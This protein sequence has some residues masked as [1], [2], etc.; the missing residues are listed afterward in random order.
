[1]S[2]RDTPIY[3]MRHADYERREV[4]I[5]RRMVQIKRRGPIRKGVRPI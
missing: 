2:K 4:D 1:M 3:E 5:K